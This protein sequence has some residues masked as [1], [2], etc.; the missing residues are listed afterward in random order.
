MVEI[1]F[2]T[3][4]LKCFGE[5][6]NQFNTMVLLGQA[7]TLVTGIWEMSLMG[8]VVG[9]VDKPYTTPD[10]VL[11]IASARKPLSL[12]LPMQHEHYH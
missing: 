2:P 3:K 8:E 4:V 7:Y 12:P 11:S 1:R 6:S 9:Q 10:E 5:P